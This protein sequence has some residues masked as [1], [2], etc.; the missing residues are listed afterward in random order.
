MKKNSALQ[1]PD[2][3]TVK[4]MRVVQYRLP[5]SPLLA[6]NFRAC[7]VLNNNDSGCTGMSMNWACD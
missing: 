2:I 1:S 4:I 3:W 5:A 7:A 6:E